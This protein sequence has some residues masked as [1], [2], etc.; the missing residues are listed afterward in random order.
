MPPP[1]A[2]ARHPN[3]VLAVLLLA[4]VSFA[5]SQT[6]VV[7]ALPA[8]AADLHASTSAASW[9]LTGYLL[10]ASVATPIAGK[11]GD[12]FGK[13]RV[14][15]GVLLVFSAGSAICALGNSI[16]VVIAGR[17]V[18]GVA[19]GVFPLSFGIIRDTFAAERVPGAIGLLS[20][21]FGIGGGIGL[22]LAGVV[23]DTLDISWLFWIGLIALPAALAAHL[24]VPPSPPRP[25]TRVDWLG[26]ALMSGALVAL[27]LG[28][29]E[30]NDWGWG[31]ARTLG[32]MAGGLALGA[33]WLWVVARIDDPLI[34]LRV[35]RRRAVATTNLAGLLVGFAMF[36][37]FLLI[38][39]FAQASES[40]GYGFGMSV[41][42]SGLVLAPAALV[43]LVVGPLAG[44]LGV[45]IGFRLTLALGAA[46]S[47]I[48]FLV[49]ALEHAHPW[50]FVI[51]GAFLGAGISFAFASM[52]NLIVGAVPQGDVGIATGINTI[53]RTVGGAFGAAVATAILTGDTL[54]G[55]P[56]PAEGAYTL[57]FLVSAGGGVLAVCAALLVPP[58]VDPG[59]GGGAPARAAPARA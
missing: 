11:L 56:V 40:T 18:Q 19:G 57:A 47:T 43:Q 38:P 39:Q 45:Q 26:A 52:A 51:G 29:T 20:A 33:V 3:Q 49:L 12:L 10:S 59:T 37:S 34:D 55:T 7:P 14:L 23:V 58:R 2:R 46:L 44:R 27:L 32:L 41:T 1:A 24:V 31:S 9:V 42:A 16:E 50:E 21:V 8:L 22:P 36:S 25:R 35:L 48:A 17:V 28:V 6:M 30:A 4:G 15:T 53:M 13:G 5:L 54:A